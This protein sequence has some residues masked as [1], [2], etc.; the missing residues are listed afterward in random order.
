MSSILIRDVAPG[1]LRALKLLARS[2]HRSLQGE[3]QA[4]LARAASMAPPEA[5]QR[6]LQLVTV[7]TER[8]CQWGR[9]TVYGDDG[10]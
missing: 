8:S 6:R 10:R 9:G 1:T 3:L 2:H 7:K 5:E 4:I